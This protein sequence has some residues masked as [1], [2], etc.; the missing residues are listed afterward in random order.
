MPRLICSL[1]VGSALGMSGALLQGMLMNGLA[2]PYLLGISAGSGLVIVFFIS[3]GLLQS[4]I[5]FAA[6]MGAILTTLIVFIL[7]KDGNKIVVESEVLNHVIS[8]S[9][10]RAFSQ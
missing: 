7:S 5:P 9:L 8:N 6:W 3:F 1:L 10:F 2:S 4:F